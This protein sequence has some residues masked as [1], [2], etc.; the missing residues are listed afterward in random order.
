[1]HHF[2]NNVI[3]SFVRLEQLLTT[4]GYSADD[5]I[6]TSCPSAEQVSILLSSASI[7]AAEAIVN[8]SASQR[9]ISASSSETGCPTPP[10]KI[11]LDKKVSF[12][13]CTNVPNHMENLTEVSESSGNNSTVTSPTAQSPV[14]PPLTS[15]HLPGH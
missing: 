9:K 3:Q 14:P 7:L 15:Q 6:I 13:G 8:F 5:M 4:N 10:R 1:M 2:Q 11:S 12:E